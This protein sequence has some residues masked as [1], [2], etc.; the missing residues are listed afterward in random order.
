[1]DVIWEGVL[2]VV[3]PCPSVVVMTTVLLNVVLVAVSDNEPKQRHERKLT[4]ECY[5]ARKTSFERE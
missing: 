4:C 2:V 1:M 5:Q 3:R